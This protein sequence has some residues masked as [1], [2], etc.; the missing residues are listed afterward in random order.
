MEQVEVGRR[1]EAIA[2]MAGEAA[3]LSAIHQ[4]ADIFLYAPAGI[5]T[6]LHVAMQDKEGP[7]SN[8]A[9]AVLSTALDGARMAAENNSPHGP[10]FLELVEAA[11]R[12]LEA[13]KG[14]DAAS[15]IRL[16]QIYAR[17]Q[18][19]PPP[20]AKLTPEVLASMTGKVAQQMPDVAG[21]LSAVVREAGQDP[22]QA[23]AALSEAL[24]AMP[25]DARAALVQAVSS[26]DDPI[27]QRLALYWLLDRVSGIRLA[28]ATALLGRANAEQLDPEIA[29]SLPSIRKWLPAEPAR[30]LVDAAIRAC[31]RRGGA[32]AQGSSW[33]VQ[34]VLASLPDG[35]GAQSIAAPVQR[36][37][38]RGVAFLLLKQGH[39]VKDAFIYG[40]ASAR[41][42]QRVVNEIG[43]QIALLEIQPD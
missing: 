4:Q 43:D 5:E 7:R 20:E 3:Q 39:G 18:L 35:A 36:G 31:L 40:C 42:Q 6:V 15:R 12:Q 23:H 32:A 25:D 27:A 13:A 11:V 37:R 38:R 29:A 2:R 17:A 22:L 10:R 34:R 1:L 21:M 9:C 26:H 41:D 16:A 8:I 33:K 14:L 28:A 24:A 30:A 19:E